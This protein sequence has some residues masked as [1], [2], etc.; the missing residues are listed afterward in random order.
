MRG[1]R[2]RQRMLLDGAGHAV[3][4]R[5]QEALLVVE[6][7]LRNAAEVVLEAHFQGV[8]AGDIGSGRRRLHRERRVLRAEE[9]RQAAQAFPSVEKPGGRLTHGNRLAVRVADVRVLVHEALGVVAKARLEQQPARQ[10]RRPCH[11]RERFVVELPIGVDLGR[12]RGRQRVD[13]VPVLRLR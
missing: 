1:L 5:V 11:G 12:E 8:G 4:E 10:G 6:L 2:E 3:V 7:R 13:P 9:D